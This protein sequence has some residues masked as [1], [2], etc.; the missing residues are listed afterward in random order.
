MFTTRPV[1]VIG[2]INIDIVLRCAHLPQPGETIAG[3]QLTYS[4]GGKGANQAVAAARLGAHT[5]LIG[6]IGD[7]A[8]A[9]LLRKTLSDAGVD[10]EW[11]RTTASSPSGTAVIHVDEHGENAITVVAGAN[12]QLCPDDLDA[13]RE[14]ISTAGVIVMQMEIP[15]PTIMQALRMAREAGVPVIL[16]PAPVPRG[17]FPPE[18]YQV[19][20]FTPNQS[21]AQLITAEPVHGIPEAKLVA[22]ELIN[23]GAKSVV[24]KLGEHGALCLDQSGQMTHIPAIPTQVVDTT[25]AGDAFTAGLATGYVEGRSLVESARLGSATAALAIRQLGAQSAMPHRGEVDALLSRHL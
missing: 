5:Y 14:L 15:L 2:S 12:G 25:A 1:V 10:L 21:E 11:L 4:P 8:H 24:M 20:V 7:D 13:A 18:L 6:R 17:E 19:D 9:P 3:D 16:D 22:A 23:R